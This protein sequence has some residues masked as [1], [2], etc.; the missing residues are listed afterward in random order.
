VQ[1][2]DRFLDGLVRA[3]EAGEA[4]NRLV[5]YRLRLLDLRAARG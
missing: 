5:H 3:A 4:L 1:L 2:L